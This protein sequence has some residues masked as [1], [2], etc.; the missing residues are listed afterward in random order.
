MTTDLTQEQV[1]QVVSERSGIEPAILKEILDGAPSV[2]DPYEGL[3]RE[4]SIIGSRVIRVLGR[5][6]GLRCGLG[7]RAPHPE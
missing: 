6:G 4:F 1:T 3:G 5:G 7:H 2:L